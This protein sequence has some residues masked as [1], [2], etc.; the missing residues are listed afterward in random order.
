MK[1]PLKSCKSMTLKNDYIDF[2][3]WNTMKFVVYFLYY[4]FPS[5]WF[6]C[7]LKMIILP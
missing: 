6:L 2:N 5:P 4:E 1:S 3:D 7:N